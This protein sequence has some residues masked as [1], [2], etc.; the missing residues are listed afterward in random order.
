MLVKK[1]LI[2]IS[3]VLGFLILALAGAV[4]I[5]SVIS[6]RSLVGKISDEQAKIE[7]RYAMRRYVRNSIANLAET[8]K[9]LGDFSAVA[10]QENKE[11]D[12]V[13]ALE[14]AAGSSGVEQKLS[15]E[16]VNQKELSSWEKEIPVKI[17]VTGAYPSVLGY[18]NALE[19]S[20]YI[21]IFNTI[22]I[23]PPRADVN[24]KEGDVTA[25]VTA[26][27][28][29]QGQNAPDFVRGQADEVPLSADDGS[30]PL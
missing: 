27:V 3:G 10:L 16:T 12:F 13:R 17:E 7:E 21:I 14:Q 4:G 11:L 24:A 9:R 26:T 5:P 1:R 18:L 19:R 25:T 8:K 30:T 6:T 22:Q 20:T 15:L 2:I 23:A 29:W 28:Y